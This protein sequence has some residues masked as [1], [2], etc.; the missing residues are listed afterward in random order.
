MLETGLYA[1]SRLR[2]PSVIYDEGLRSYKAIA[3]I[4]LKSSQSPVSN[5]TFCYL[6]SGAIFSG[7]ILSLNKKPFRVTSKNLG[8]I[9][10]G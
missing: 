4:Q 9:I 8:E 2:C 5:V 6:E 3:F 7:N 10:Y 1:R